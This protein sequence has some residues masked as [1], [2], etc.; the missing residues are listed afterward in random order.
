MKLTLAALILFSGITYIQAKD[1][2]PFCGVRPFI[3]RSCEN[4]DS[5]SYSDEYCSVQ[6]WCTIDL[7]LYLDDPCGWNTENNWEGMFY[8]ENSA[9][10]CAAVTCPV[11]YSCWYG[12]CYKRPNCVK[13]SDDN[14]DD[15]GGGD[16]VEVNPAVTPTSTP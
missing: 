7:S 4:D 2:E 3:A 1:L 11:G 13:N 14:N 5:C 16:T 10:Q 9:A 8:D 15:N 12:Q 6:H